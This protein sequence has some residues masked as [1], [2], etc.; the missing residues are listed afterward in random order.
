MGG[1][2]RVSCSSS[3]RPQWMMLGQSLKDCRSQKSNW[4]IANIFPSDRWVALRVVGSASSLDCRNSTIAANSRPG[5]TELQVNYMLDVKKSTV[6]RLRMNFEQ[7]GDDIKAGHAL[8]PPPE[9][10]RAV[11]IEEVMIGCAFGMLQCL[12]REPRL[13][14]MLGKIT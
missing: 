3:T 10:E 6:E 13:V 7:L 1:M 4:L 11:L 2:A 5:V 9:T 8:A 12:D 14:Y